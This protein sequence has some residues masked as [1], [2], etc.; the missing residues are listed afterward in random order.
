MAC[1]AVRSSNPR[2]C[3]TCTME[4]VHACSPFG[5]T[6]SPRTV[7]RSDRAE[8]E[9]LSDTAAP[10]SF[11]RVRPFPLPDDVLLESNSSPAER[12]PAVMVSMSRGSDSGD[13]RHQPDRDGA[14]IV[15][16]SRAVVMVGPGAV[17]VMACLDGRARAL[18]IP[19]RLSSLVLGHGVEIVIAS[20]ECGT[21]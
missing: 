2:S 14:V 8:D 12:A 20:D 15:M 7:S 18:T 19:F 16:G 13:G 11:I 10:V 6:S 17:A 5:Q 9:R 21:E 3:M 4:E 1:R